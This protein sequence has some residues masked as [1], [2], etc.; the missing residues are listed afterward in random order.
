MKSAQFLHLKEAAA[1]TLAVTHLQLQTNQLREREISNKREKM[2]GRGRSRTQRKHFSQSRENA[3][4]RPK[5]DA[6]AVDSPGDANNSEHRNWQ[7]FLTQNPAF[8]EYYKVSFRDSLLNTC[9]L[10]F[11]YFSDKL[12][13]LVNF[14]I[15]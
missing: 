6:S 3:W 4:K 15:M 5:S 8:D 13:F 11:F 14:S 7:P 1:P 9:Y 2:G 12:F 10:L